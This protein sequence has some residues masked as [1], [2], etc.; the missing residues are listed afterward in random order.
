[1]TNRP[2]THDF[3]RSE[4]DGPGAEDPRLRALSDRLERL[5]RDRA[6]RRAELELSPSVRAE[7]TGLRKIARRNGTT[8]EAWRGVAPP[9]LAD[10][11]RVLGWR[12]G[13]LELAV[14]TQG[15]RH[16]LGQWLRTGGD[17][18]LAQALGRAIPEIR[19]LVQRDTRG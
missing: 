16:E 11:V 5:R 14:E 7:Q 13:R 1:M 3:E 9:A 15:A 4:P 10:A 8:V 12:R 6:V 19:V 17:R 18:Q 2:D